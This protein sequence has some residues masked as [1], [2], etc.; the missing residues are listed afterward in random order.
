MQSKSNVTGV[1]SPYSRSVQSNLQAN[2]VGCIGSVCRMTFVPTLRRSVL[3]VPG[4]D[5]H[6][7]EKSRSLHA[8][9]ICLDLE[10]SVTVDCKTEARQNVA[11]VLQSPDFSCTEVFVRINLPLDPW[12]WAD[13]DST[14]TQTN[15]ALRGYLLP[16]IESAAEI[17]AVTALIDRLGRDRGINTQDLRLILCIETPLGIVNLRDIAMAESR[18][19]ALAFGA[20]DY[21]AALGRTERLSADQ[22]L[23]PRSVLATHAHAF[24][25]QAIDMVYAN[26]HDTEGLRLEA[27]NSRSLGYHGKLIIHPQ[28][29]EPVHRAYAISPEEVE[30]AQQLLAAFNDPI[31]Q[32]DGTFS[33]HGYMVDRPTLEAARRIVAQ[34]QAT[35]KESKTQ[36]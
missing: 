15:V 21:S 34:E 35:L 22:L 1:L 25:L 14:L 9:V 10:D 4:I 2:R 36:S 11:E 13:I 23:Y 8:D 19:V 28:Q 3:F 6:K 5:Q 33:W 16:K 26:F 12:G 29:I 32:R 17:R 18:I 30:Q 7:L 31:H 27:L 24:G 20:I